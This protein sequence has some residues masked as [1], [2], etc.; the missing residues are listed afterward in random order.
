MIYVIS[1]ARYRASRNAKD[2]ILTIVALQYTTRR[3]TP[4]TI[5]LHTIVALQYTMRRATPKTIYL[6]SIVALQY[7]TRALE[8]TSLLHSNYSG[9]RQNHRQK[10]IHGIRQTFGL[11]TAYVKHLVCTRHTSNV[12]FV[13]FFGTCRLFC[14]QSAARASGGRGPLR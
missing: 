11:H 9:A 12:W 6:H 1:N 2:D 8:M 5:Y 13:K 7:T 4:K 14:V 3:A 10:Q